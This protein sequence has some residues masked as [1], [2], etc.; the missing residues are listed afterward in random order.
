MRVLTVIP[1]P[2]HSSALL[3]S[4]Q[5]ATE[6]NPTRITYSTST[7]RNPQP[8]PYA[9]CGYLAG[10]IGVPLH[11]Q[12]QLD[13]QADSCCTHPSKYYCQNP[14]CGYLAGMVGVPFD[15][16]RQQLAAHHLRRPRRVQRQPP[17]QL[18]RVRAPPPVGGDKRC[19]VLELHNQ[20]IHCQAVRTL[21]PPHDGV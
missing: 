13:W 9:G 8:K 17:R 2:H 1:H 3:V 16:Q 5:K 10:M 4:A 21:A 7:Q 6:A 20:G 11:E 15:K 12:R 18:R 19:W 14:V